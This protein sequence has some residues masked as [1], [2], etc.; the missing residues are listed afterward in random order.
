[1]NILLS[2]LK[3]ELK[4]VKRL[5]KK[6]LREL[7]K[8]P[9]GNLI[10][11]NIK[12]KEYC[13]LTYRDGKAVRQKYLGKLTEDEIEKYHNISSRRKELRGK[14]KNIREQKKILERALRGK[15]K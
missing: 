7:N 13:Y 4:T 3:E 9:I 10:L 6:Y 11:R 14:L 15:A 2:T 5:E 12:G 8:I 1:M